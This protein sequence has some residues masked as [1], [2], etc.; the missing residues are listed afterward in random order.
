MNEN[1]FTGQAVPCITKKGSYIPSNRRSALCPAQH[2]CAHHSPVKAFSICAETPCHAGGPTATGA[3]LNCITMAA[4]ALASSFLVTQHTA[5]ITSLL[6]LS[7]SCPVL[8]GIISLHGPCWAVVA[9]RSPIFQWDQVAKMKWHSQKLTLF[10]PE[11]RKWK[12]RL[13]GLHSSS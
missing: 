6:R 13:M 5:G 11:V 10:L 8:C 1:C 2:L 9:V 3:P 12:G 7:S 4:S